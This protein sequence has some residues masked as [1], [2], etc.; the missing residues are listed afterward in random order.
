MLDESRHQSDIQRRTMSTLFV[1]GVTLKS[2]DV[3][4]FLFF[5]RLE[6]NHPISF[7]KTPPNSKSEFAL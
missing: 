6:R 3:N 5:S 4:E 2:D 1:R 7:N